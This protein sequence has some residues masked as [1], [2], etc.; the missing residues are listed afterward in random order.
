M[1]AQDLCKRF[2][3]DDLL[4]TEGG[5]QRSPF[6]GI[7]L[8]KGTPEYFNTLSECKDIVQT[9]F[10]SKKTPVSSV[11]ESILP[12]VASTMSQKQRRELFRS[13]PVVG[14]SKRTRNILE[15]ERDEELL[16]LPEYK[17]YAFRN[18]M[19]RIDFSK[20]SKNQS[21]QIT[22]Q[23]YPI[24]LKYFRKGLPIPKEIE[25]FFDN[26]PRDFYVQLLNIAV[27][28][29]IKISSYLLNVILY[30]LKYNEKLIL[31]FQNVLGRPYPEQYIIYN[32]KFNRIE[33]PSD[34]LLNQRIKDNKIF[35]S[36]LKIKNL[37]PDVIDFLIKNY[38]NDVKKL[39]LLSFLVDKNKSLQDV[40][41]DAKVEDLESVLFILEDR[42]YKSEFNKIIPYYLHAVIQNGPSDKTENIF[43]DLI[44]SELDGK[45]SV[46]ILTLWKS[47]YPQSIQKMKNEESYVDFLA[48]IYAM[49]D[50][51]NFEFLN[52][53][54]KELSDDLEA[55]HQFIESLK[56]HYIGL[57]QM[58]DVIGK[59]SKEVPKSVFD[60]IYK[61][62]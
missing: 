43:L 47:I 49:G 52:F 60:Y 35:F 15:A 54:F 19:N 50:T 27:D 25:D 4:I 32:L 29:N 53:F 11:S 41:L 23:A 13:V 2:V 6:T 8:V 36:L 3:Q 24:F 42:K 28:E 37:S 33:D 56:Y 45:T 1:N 58:I 62:F 16:K 9:S 44:K 61:K 38:S 21:F 12:L 22:D 51:N 31:Y 26:L 40:L 14:S 59:R 39:I 34:L 48:D 10:P 30:M 5:R 57:N 20:L 18:V 55:F 46:D 7:K 17:K